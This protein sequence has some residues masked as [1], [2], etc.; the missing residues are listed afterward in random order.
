MFKRTV[1]LMLLQGKRRDHKSAVVCKYH[2][3]TMPLIA[4]LIFFI[5]L[6][7]EL[8]RHFC[9]LVPAILLVYGFQRLVAYNSEPHEV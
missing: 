9:S 6:R 3:T 2:P 8:D 4:A 7:I 5:L 1:L